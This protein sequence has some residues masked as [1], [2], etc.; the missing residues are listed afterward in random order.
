[1][2]T[3]RKLAAILSAD[4]AGYSRLMADDEAATLRSLNDARALFRERITAHGGRLIDSAG[5][6]I[7][8]EFPSAVEAVDCANENSFCVEHDAPLHTHSMG[9]KPRQ[10]AK[11]IRFSPSRARRSLTITWS[12]GS[13][14]TTRRVR[15]ISP[16][17]SR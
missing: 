3:H 12:R 14:A 8:A 10:R 15:A 13:R 6:S 1:M 4:A 9:Q 2:T 7:L 5:D 16:R 11:G 17:A